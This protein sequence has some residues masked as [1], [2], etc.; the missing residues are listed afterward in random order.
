MK[1]RFGFV[2]LLLIAASSSPARAED[3]FSQLSAADWTALGDAQSPIL[4]GLTTAR[5]AVTARGDQLQALFN[6]V[7]G[8]TLSAN[9]KALIQG[10]PAQARQQA[11]SDL[12]LLTQNGAGATATGVFTLAGFHFE[13]LSQA[14]SAALKG[15]FLRLYPSTEKRLSRILD[16]NR[17]EVILI[18]GQALLPPA[19][20]KAEPG[21]HFSPAMPLA[22]YEAAVAKELAGL[23]ADLRSYLQE[24][25]KGGHFQDLVNE[26]SA[27]YTNDVWGMP[28]WERPHEAGQ[29]AAQNMATYRLRRLKSKWGLSGAQLDHALEAYA[30]VGEQAATN[31]EAALS[32]FAAKAAAVALAPALLPVATT[33]LLLGGF[34]V[35]IGF[36]ALD[37]AGSAWIDQAFQ[38]GGYGCQFLRQLDQ[39][40]PHGFTMALLFAPLPKIEKLAAAGPLIARVGM[41]AGSVAVVGAAGFSAVESGKH[42]VSATKAERKASATQGPESPAARAFRA[43]AAQSAVHTVTDGALAAFGAGSL[44]PK[45]SGASATAVAQNKTGVSPVPTAPGRKVVAASAAPVAEPKLDGWELQKLED[46]A[47]SAWDELTRTNTPGSNDRIWTSF[48]GTN[49]EGRTEPQILKEL[50]R[51][52]LA[53]LEAKGTRARIYSRS[54]PHILVIEPLRDGGPLNQIAWK[55]N[56]KFGTRVIFDPST[57]TKSKS[58]AFFEAKT[59]E[60]SISFKEVLYARRFSEFK[61]EIRHLIR[62][63][64][65][66]LPFSGQI[67][68]KRSGEGKPAHDVYTEYMNLNEV[69]TFAWDMVYYAKQFKFYQGAEQDWKAIL[70]RSRTATFILAQAEEALLAVKKAD[71]FFGLG[72]ETIR[73][74]V[75]GLGEIHLEVPPALRAKA[76]LRRDIEGV[77]LHSA[78]KQDAPETW[79]FLHKR[80]D[81]ELA[82]ISDLRGRIDFEYLKTLKT[83]KQRRA[84]AEWLLQLPKKL[85]SFDQYF[86]DLAK[87]DQEA[88]MKTAEKATAEM[89]SLYVAALSNEAPLS[90]T[91]YQWLQTQLQR[92]ELSFFSIMDIYTQDDAMMAHK[93]MSTAMEAQFKEHLEKHTIDEWYWIGQA[94]ETLADSY[95]EQII[96]AHRQGK[97]ETALR[98]YDGFLDEYAQAL[99]HYQ[100][101]GAKKEV[102][103]LENR[104]KARF[105]RLEEIQIP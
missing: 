95:F 80:I 33:P 56:D 90:L 51:A 77:G 104:M 70:E 1:R 38:G 75:A 66:D 15:A 35:G 71:R 17:R 10:M 81:F 78:P 59:N 40:L 57:L 67:Q 34:T 103:A 102:K 58:L 89:E 7:F 60:I 9:Q 27:F 69:I 36:S 65:P 55:L 92:K 44:L 94:K 32:D 73:V 49:P 23:Q 54:Q 21:Q 25:R 22:A 43:E 86:L 101:A 61:H 97:S 2:A 4:R 91:N 8:R 14:D 19:L 83:Q 31:R 20:P 6:Q 46:R 30:R 24:A 99:F 18:E 41:K 93:A 76:K 5:A 28:S 37:M 88:L 29:R 13:R 98:N 68:Y 48:F 45:A 72:N 84:H 16:S 12:K 82:M 11:L 64:L 62:S 85:R 74:E 42:A 96:Q 105:Q 63:F 53:L 79:A 47:K 26:I 39:K 3:C 100:T 50:N 52:V 87:K